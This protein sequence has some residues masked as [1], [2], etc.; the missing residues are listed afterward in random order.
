MAAAYS[1]GIDLGTTNSVVAFVKL[2]EE[3]A[4]IELLNI[5]QL[6]S[7]ATIENRLSLPSFCYLATDA[8]KEKHSYDLPWEKGR[9]FAIGEIAR[10]QAAEIPTRT[11]AAAKS[12]LAHSKVDRRESI[13]PWNAPSDVKK[14]SPFEAS[15]RYLEHIVTVWNTQFPDAPIAQQMV[16]LTVPASFDVSAR[17]L[18]MEAAIKAGLPDNLL[19]LEEPQA[20]VYAWLAD[21]GDGWRKKLSV[22]DTL[23]ICDIG[24]GTTDFT[25]IGVSEE[26]GDLTLKRIAVGNHILVG[27]DNMDL[28]LAHFARNIFSEKGTTLDAWQAVSLWHSCRV[29]KEQ[30]LSENPPKSHPVTI[31]GR[32][33]KLIG[34]TISAELESEAVS[35]LLLDGFFPACSPDASP[36]RRP[37]SGFKELGLPFEHDTAITKHLVQFLRAHNENKSVPLQPSHVLFNGGVFKA[38]QFRKRL[39]EV[40]QSWFDKSSTSSLEAAPDYDFAVA[41]GAA[42]YAFVKQG[43]GIRIR[44]GTGR[45]YYVGIETSGPAVPGIERPL[46]ALCVVPFGMEEG[47]EIEVPSDEIGLV[48]GEPVKF[49]FFSS[50]VRKKDKPGDLLTQW[51]ENELEET[52]SLE[53]KLPA[54]ERF[55]EGYVPVHFLSRITELGVFELWCKSTIS[56]DSWKLQFS[57]REKKD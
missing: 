22:N 34:G 57:V 16:V 40:L 10:K 5:Q 33:S 41:R 47:S 42:Y 28:T 12:W 35:S 43:R 24:G 20:A 37:A 30:L 45:S 52:D 49:R 18:T 38:A 9:D 1:I 14:I 17:E 54:D 25:L 32:G 11:I 39:L 19:L 15:R 44:G 6:T 27:G 26:E 8:E 46:Y 36:S 13:L 23:L 56:E 48:V 7:P 31:L 4:E 51:G 50:S 55:V 21:S 2:Q 3:N 29:A 53:S